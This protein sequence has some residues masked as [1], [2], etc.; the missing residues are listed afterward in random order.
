MHR[1]LDTR[2]ER[3]EVTPAVVSNNLITKLTSL[4]ADVLV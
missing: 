4:K 3:M 2:S 1:L